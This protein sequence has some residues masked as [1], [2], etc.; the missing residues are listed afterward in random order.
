MTYQTNQ[1]VICNGNPE[2]YVIRKCYETMYEVR[3]WSGSRLIGDVLVS[4][5]SLNLGNKA[6]A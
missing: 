3:L 5:H 4:E 6:A 2:G 1:K